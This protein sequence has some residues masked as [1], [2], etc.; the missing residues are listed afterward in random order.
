MNVNDIVRE[1]IS[2]CSC[3]GSTLLRVDDF[4]GNGGVLCVWPAF[5]GFRKNRRTIP[6][7]QLEVV[8]LKEQLAVA[9]IDCKESGEWPVADLLRQARDR[10]EQL[11]E[12]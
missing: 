10:I 8:P 6:E 2:T 1:K 4:D 12:I 5:L 7:E 3:C 9:A 11:E